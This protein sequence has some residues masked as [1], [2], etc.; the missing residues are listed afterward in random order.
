MCMIWSNLLRFTKVR[1][2]PRIQG[3]IYIYIHIMFRTLPILDTPQKKKS[4]LVSRYSYSKRLE[5][6]SFYPSS[7]LRMWQTFATPT[8]WGLYTNK[9]GVSSLAMLGIHKKTFDM[10]TDMA[11]DQGTRGS[12]HHQ[13]WPK[14][15][16][17]SRGERP[18]LRASPREW[19]LPRPK[20]RNALTDKTWLMVEH[21]IS[22]WNPQFVPSMTKDPLTRH[23]TRIDWWLVDH[24][25]SSFRVFSISMWN[26]T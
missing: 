6:I 20:N 9:S 24:L 26:P 14:T 3:R 21:L 19:T 7:W 18:T 2:T 25:E 5:R 16:L 17:G 12:I 10:F 8:L 1:Y 22:S 13:R 4:S 15:T 23:E 11:P